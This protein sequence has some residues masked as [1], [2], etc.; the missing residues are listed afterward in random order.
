MGLLWFML[1]FMT[2]A[3][4]LAGLAFLSV[5]SKQKKIKKEIDKKNKERSKL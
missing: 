1:G 4:A 2:G 5:K 3:F